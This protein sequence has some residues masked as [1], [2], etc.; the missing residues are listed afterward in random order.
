MLKAFVVLALLAFCG[1][2]GRRKFS[3]PGVSA[4][5]LFSNIPS[6]TSV[7]ITSDFSGAIITASPEVL[8]LNL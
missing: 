1:V 8:V 6:W 3:V 5:R 2:H 4:P 7:G